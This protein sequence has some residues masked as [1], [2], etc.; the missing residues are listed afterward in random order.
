[1]F[2][3]HLAPACVEKYRVSQMG[4]PQGWCTLRDQ[5][6]RA[7]R[8]FMSPELHP[9]VLSSEASLW[10]GSRIKRRAGRWGGRAIFL[11][12]SFDP[13][14]DFLKWLQPGYLG[15]WL[16]KCWKDVL[17]AHHISTLAS[18][19]TPFIWTRVDSKPCYVN[20]GGTGLLWKV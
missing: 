7:T 9:H 14:T 15:T 2:Y 19:E 8:F 10:E 17:V 1:M 18:A 3:I 11:I 13:T 12:S 20:M 4:E 6:P 5:G 16:N